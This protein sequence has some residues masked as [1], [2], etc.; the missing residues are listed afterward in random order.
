MMTVTTW[1]RAWCCI[2]PCVMT[3][4]VASVVDKFRQACHFR[5][6]VIRGVIE[7]SVLNEEG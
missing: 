1:I 5:S 7:R 6:L 2:R 3:M 4:Q